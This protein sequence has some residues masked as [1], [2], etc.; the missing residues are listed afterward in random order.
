[1]CY[2]C[3]KCKNHGVLMWKKDHKKNCAYSDCRCE[4]CDLI[5]T[6]RALDQHIKKNR[7]AAPSLSSGSSSSSSSR[8]SATPNISPEAK[9]VL[10]VHP[11][12]TLPVLVQHQQQPPL[13]MPVPLP[14]MLPWNSMPWCPVPSFFNVQGMFEL[15]LILNNLAA[16]SSHQPML[17]FGR[18]LNLT[19][20]ISRSSNA[21]CTGTEKLIWTIETR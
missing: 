18:W 21:L 14:I 4:Q 17:S 10:P 8:S 19:V 7:V 12:P 13:A 2:F 1:M 20:G 16:T 5:D 3:Q 9:P 6:R 15:Q 11:C